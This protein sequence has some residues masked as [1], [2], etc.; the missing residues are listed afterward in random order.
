ME[1]DRKNKT[2]IVISKILNSFRVTVTPQAAINQGACVLMFC[3]SFSTL[4][5]SL[6]LIRHKFHSETIKNCMLLV[7][8]LVGIEPRTLDLLV[9]ALYQSATL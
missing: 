2:A 5:Y 6:S 7:C 9:E 1:G 4:D 3:V 8:T